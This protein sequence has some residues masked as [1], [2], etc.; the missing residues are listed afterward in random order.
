[1]ANI[2]GTNATEILNGTVASDTIQGLGGSDQLNGLGGADTISGGDGADTISGGDGDDI[3]YGHSAADLDPH[4]GDI[5]ATLL[6]NVGSGA[7]FVTGAPGDDG[8]VYALRK[9]VGD[10][11]RINTSTGAQSTFLDIPT[12]QFSSGGERGVLGLAFHPDYE[13]NGRFFVFLTKPSGDIEV[14]EYARSANPAL[15][16]PRSS[17]RSSPSRIRSSPITMAALSRS[18]PMAISI[19]RPATAAAAT[20]PTT[21]PRT[22]MSCWARSSGS[23]STAMTFPADATRNY[24]IPDGNPFAGAIPGAAEIWAYGCAIRGA[25][26]SIPLTGDLYIGDV[27]QSAREEVNFDAAG[28]PGGLNYGWD[29]REGTLRGRAS[30][31]THRSPSS[32]PF[33]TILAISA[34]ASRAAMSIAD[35]PPGSR[36]PISS[37]ILSPGGFSR[38]AW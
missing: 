22:S 34:T 32:S 8:F 14:R 28:G 24:A 3:I 20:T 2:I 37:A 11:V 7:V 13:T 18:G 33:S 4:S 1:M 27:G 35:R 31:L 15:A 9:D 29:Y 6:A 10:I 17:S 12:A 30:H 25:S 19:S 21:T 36:A 26:A 5:N 23:T 38:C 16:N